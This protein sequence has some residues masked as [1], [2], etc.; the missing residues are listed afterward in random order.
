MDDTAQILAPPPVEPISRPG[1][2]TP[3]ESPSLQHQLPGISALA[4][5]NAEPSPPPATDTPPIQQQQQQQ[6]QPQ[7][8]PPQTQSPFPPNV[9]NGSAPAATSSAGMV[10]LSRFLYLSDASTHLAHFWRITS[11]QPPYHLHDVASWGP[12]DNRL[13]GSRDR[14]IT[15]II[16]PGRCEISYLAGEKKHYLITCCSAKR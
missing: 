8:Q 16:T 11:L 2:T 9:P 6:Q 5:A 15:T 4:A 7:A 14:V 13:R 12:I 1:S 10:S 3:A